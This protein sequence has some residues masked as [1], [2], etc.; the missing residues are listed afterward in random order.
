MSTELRKK[1]IDDI[2]P[3]TLAECVML[4]DGTSNSIKDYTVQNDYIINGINQE[5]ENLKNGINITPGDN[6]NMF[7]V[8]NTYNLFDVS[9]SLTGSTTHLMEIKGGHYYKSNINTQF[10][11][12]SNE[13]DLIA[14]ISG[15]MSQ[16]PV[17]AKYLKLNIYG[18]RNTLLV[19]H[20]TYDLP[21][22]PHTEIV[23][24]E[25]LIKQ[26]GY[27]VSK[28][29]GKT[30]WI[31]G[32]SI[33]TG[34]DNG[35][36]YASEPY[37]YLLAMER[38]IDVQNDAVSGYTIQNMYNNKV[39]KMPATENAPDLITIMIGTNNHGFNLA[40]GSID[41]SVDTDTF[42]GNYKKTIEYLLD[43]YP[44]AT[45]GLITP[46][47]RYFDGNDNTGETL[48]GPNKLVDF[49]NATIEIGK[50]YCLPVLDL[51]N[52]LGFT[53]FTETNRN[54]Y[55][56]NGDG[57]HPNNFG[58]TFIKARVGDFIERI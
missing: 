1:V 5:I 47:K 8:V 13:T 6:S 44:Y 46:I 14:T 22:K 3:V 28:W 24:K 54:R 12:Y 20:G 36:T 9:Q 48:K 50:L 17:N 57:T 42:C 43:R 10:M 23:L 39:T 52:N 40:C 55:Y 30:W 29:K 2:A 49:A 26:V 58:H 45:I 35:S 56:C 31:L 21:Y 27:P 4:G 51:Y 37:H 25:S 32:D 7:E 18:D 15:Y 38:G 11:Y 16:A 41:D 33:S 19:T 34:G 53:P